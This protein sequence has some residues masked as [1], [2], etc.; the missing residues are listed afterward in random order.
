[1][2]GGPSRVLTS[3]K[4][5]LRVAISIMT[6]ELDGLGISNAREMRGG[7]FP[8]RERWGEAWGG[9]RRPALRKNSKQFLLSSKRLRGH[10]RRGS[11]GEGV[12]SGV[13]K[14]SCVLG[15]SSLVL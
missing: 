7:G 8:E 4:A 13:G 10:L 12:W 14:L 9:R 3:V 15:P 2:I 5:G 6:G 11:A 1:M